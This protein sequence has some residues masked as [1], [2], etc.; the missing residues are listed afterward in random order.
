MTDVIVTAKWTV[1]D[2]AQSYP[3]GI[4][5]EELTVWDRKVL[6][7]SEQV[8]GFAVLTFALFSKHQTYLLSPNNEKHITYRMSA[9]ALA[10]H[11][12]L[13]EEDED[14][15]LTLEET[16]ALLKDTVAALDTFFMLTSGFLVFFMQCGFCMVSF[17][18]PRFPLNGSSVFVALRR[19]RP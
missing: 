19:F 13:Q 17:S 8:R 15:P 2:N 3:S 18:R 4:N 14:P 16:E 7:S 9:A 6:A 11:R 5:Y 10:L 12:K 1:W